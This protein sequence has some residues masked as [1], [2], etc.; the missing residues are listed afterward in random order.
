MSTMI[1]TTVK[2]TSNHQK[3]KNRLQEQK[4]FDKILKYL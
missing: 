2:F 1:Y 3:N 4:I